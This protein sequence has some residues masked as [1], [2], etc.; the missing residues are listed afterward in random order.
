MGAYKGDNGGGY[1][2]PPIKH[3]FK[4]K[5]PGG[6]GRPKGS[7]SMDAALAKVFRGKVPYKENGK[8]VSG[9]ATEA[10]SKRVLQHG[11]AG[12]HRA[13]LEVLKLAQK[14]GPQEA[15]T[16][17]APL[18]F[19]QEL[20]YG[21]LRSLGKL[22][23]KATGDVAWDPPHD[24]PFER[25]TDPDNPDNYCHETTVD[26]LHYR[27]C[28]IDTVEDELIGVANRAYFSAALAQRPGCYRRNG[29]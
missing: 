22:L 18:P 7:T 12:T 9:A 17:L 27:R 13:T 26:G 2:N 11:L 29:G 20:T 6:P 15:E 1:G 28:R 16:E 3:Q 4:K 23:A 24:D 10:L 19:L 5:A 25:Y 14:Y 8:P 21:E